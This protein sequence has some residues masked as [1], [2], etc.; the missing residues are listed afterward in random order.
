[1]TEFVKSFA[2]NEMYKL[3]KKINDYAEE[4]NLQIKQIAFA[5]TPDKICDNR[6]LVLF[7]KGE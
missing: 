5:Y 3:E 7:S 6:A 4:N 2:E 1:M